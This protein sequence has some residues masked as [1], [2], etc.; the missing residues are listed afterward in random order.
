MSKAIVSILVLAAILL[1]GTFGYVAIE[2]CTPLD[3]LYMTMITITTVGFSET[4]PLSPAGRVFTIL[5][6][7]SGVSYVLYVFTK[8]TEAVVEGGVRK[9]VGRI[10]MD[11]KLSRL[12]DHYIVC[13]YGRIGKVICQSFKDKGLDFVIIDNDAE[14]IKEIAALGYFFLEGEATDDDMLIKAGVA[15]ARGLI[16]VV[17]SDA[18]N[19]YITLSAKELNPDL[20]IMA[21]SSGKR[22]ADSKLKRAGADRVISPYFIGGRQMANMILRPTVIDFLDLTVHE[23]ESGLRLEEVRLGAGAVFVG[24]SL[25]ESGLRQKYDIIVVAIKRGGR[26]R[27]LFNPSHETVLEGGD[28]L[29][30][31]G[32]SENVERLKRAC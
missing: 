11:K 2:G 5:L 18:D 10:N 6:I 21:R 26:D 20:F 12:H 31:L 17:S 25:M 27:M 23:G 14:E 32:E 19:V 8:F 4:F 15:R 9:V 29:I 28:T 22:G 16:A 13:G 24:Q 30:V 7:V 3:G 1:G